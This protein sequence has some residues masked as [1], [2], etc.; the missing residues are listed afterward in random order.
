MRILII[1]SLPERRSLLWIALLA[2][3]LVRG[4]SIWRGL[5]SLRRLA[6]LSL[7][8]LLRPSNG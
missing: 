4:K 3:A 1:L 7:A 8:W 2:I 6:P 5:L